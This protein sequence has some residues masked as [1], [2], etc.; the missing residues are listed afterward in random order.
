MQYPDGITRNTPFKTGDVRNYILHLRK[1][2][3]PHFQPCKPYYPANRPPGGGTVPEY[4]LLPRGV[5][6]RWGQQM[7]YHGRKR[8]SRQKMFHQGSKMISRQK[9]PH[10]GSKKYQ[11]RKCFITVAHRNLNITKGQGTGKFVRCNDVSLYR[12]PFSYI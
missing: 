8:I 7:F 12:G 6:N 4:T 11:G 1:K 2:K 3:N 5:T 9:M 10:H